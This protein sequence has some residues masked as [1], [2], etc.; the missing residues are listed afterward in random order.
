[1]LLRMEYKSNHSDV[2]HM[3][4]YRN[5]SGYDSSCH[6]CCDSS[7]SVFRFDSV[8]LFHNI[9]SLDLLVSIQ[10]KMYISRISMIDH[11]PGQSSQTPF[12]KKELK[13]KM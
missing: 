1:M 3:M 11:L 4:N 6:Y 10:Q 8:L 5:S 2:L 12:Q 9:L 7:R 13:N